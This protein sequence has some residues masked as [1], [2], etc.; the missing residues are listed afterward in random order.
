MKKP[1][2]YK[3]RRA[4][5][6]F[7]KSISPPSV[8]SLR[9]FGFKI[10]NNQLPVFDELLAHGRSPFLI[11]SSH[12]IDETKIEGMFRITGLGACRERGFKILTD[13]FTDTI[14][15]ARLFPASAG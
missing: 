14:G 4:E 5:T 9:R 12:L 15:S 1:A 7:L 2:Q 13:F 10:E 11:S 6:R 8:A 3:S